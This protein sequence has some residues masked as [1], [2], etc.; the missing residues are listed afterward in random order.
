V[1]SFFLDPKYEAVDPNHT[2]VDRGRDSCTARTPLSANW[3]NLTGFNPEVLSV[4]V[5]RL[6]TR[7]RKWR[8]D[9]KV[10]ENLL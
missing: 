4:E 5:R 8:I 1:G 2:E 3:A 6:K 10:G 7:G 9:A